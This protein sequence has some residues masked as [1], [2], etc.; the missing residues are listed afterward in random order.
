M[1]ATSVAYEFK[2]EAEIHLIVPFLKP[3]SRTQA[4]GTPLGYSGI[5]LSDSDS[6]LQR[7]FSQRL[8]ILA[9]LPWCLLL[10]SETFFQTIIWGNLKVNSLVSHISGTMSIH[11]PMYHTDYHSI[12]WLIYRQHKSEFKYFYWL[13]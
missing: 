4:L 2:C 10:F 9:T 5:S 12:I 13:K 3:V 1:K 8:L 6:L 11:C 7:L